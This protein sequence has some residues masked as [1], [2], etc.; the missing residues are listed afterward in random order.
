MISFIIHS[1]RQ[2]LHPDDKSQKEAKRPLSVKE[3]IAV[4]KHLKKKRDTKLAKEGVSC[5]L[6]RE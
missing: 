2:W 1:L 6:P 3:K 5:G 4:L